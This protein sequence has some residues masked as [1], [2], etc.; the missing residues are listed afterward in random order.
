MTNANTTPR[1]RDIVLAGEAAAEVS[2]GALSGWIGLG[3]LTRA[4]ILAALVEAE[5]PAEWAPAAKSDVAQ[6]GRAMTALNN[7]GFIARRA[8]RA[9]WRR[10]DIYSSERERDYRVRWVAV[11][12][13]AGAAELGQPV[14]EVVL[15][16]ELHDG[17]SDLHI[18]GHAGLAARVQADYEAFR[19]A[20]LY[21]A[22]DVTTWLRGILIRH[23]GATRYAMGY[24]I[25]AG[26]REVA[27]RLV[28]T[29]AKRWGSS[30]ANPLLPVATSDELKVGIARGFADEVAGVARSL[31]SARETARKDAVKA[32]AAEVE[33]AEKA[34]R[35]APA[36]PV[37]VEIS[38]GTAARL[39]RDLGDV[40]ERADAYRV[41]VGDAALAD[42]VA[43]LRALHAELSPI[44]DDVSQRFALLELAPLDVEPA[45]A[46]VASPAEKAAERA[47]VERQA[48]LAAQKAAQ[49]PAQP[50]PED[51]YRVARA[52]TG[53]SNRDF[54]A[55]CVSVFRAREIA[56]DAVTPT[57]WAEVA[58][59]LAGQLPAATEPAP[60]PEPEPAPKAPPAPETK[61]APSDA[62]TR[63]SLLELN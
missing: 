39:L 37:N 51:R 38:A 44:A 35:P 56:P 11:A 53:M 49:Q 54:R 21:A 60:E 45:P 5:L 8:R 58:E 59:Q 40:D 43:Q 32:H 10:V 4:A 9:D 33:E 7:L 41:I 3:S 42:A 6:L 36:A 50:S 46:P 13:D 62:D 20:E 17:S 23:C 25:P 63:F 19:D 57:I 26:G 16:V 14:G 18:E 15:T 12:A 61:L 28:S 24:Y 47:L 2:S 31:Q 52:R 55:A 1:F 22:G 48:E 27:Q 34:G 29:L 30:W